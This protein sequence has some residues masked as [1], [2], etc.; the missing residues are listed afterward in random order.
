MASV[1]AKQEI[2]DYLNSHTDQYA[3]MADRIWEKPE[4][5]WGEF[6]AAELQADFLEKE[7]FSVQRGVAG[8][9]TAFIAEWGV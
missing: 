1:Q 3:E 2:L 6:F 5:L 8:M 9:P 4:I 7:G